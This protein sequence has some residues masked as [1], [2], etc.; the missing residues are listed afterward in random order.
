MKTKNFTFVSCSDSLPI[1]VLASMPD[2]GRPAALLQLAH[3]M[4]GCKERF[5]PFMEYMADNGIGCVANDH[6]GHGE[7]IRSSGDL[8]YMYGNGGESLVEDMAQLTF[9]IYDAFPG[10]PVFLLGHSMGSMAARVYT[11]RHDDLIE[12]L[13]LCGSPSWT[14]F[15]H[16]GYIFTGAIDI[17]GGGRLRPAFLSDFVSRQYNRHF[18]KEGPRAWTCSDPEI[19]KEFENNP[20]CNYTFTVNGMLNLMELMLMTYRSNDWQMYHP[21]M[22]VL[23][24]SGEDDPCCRSEKM[25]HESAKDMC[26]HGYGNV[27]SALYRGMR[28][29]ILNEKEKENV[30][31]D[32]LLF[33]KSNIIC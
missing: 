9:L 19:R 27:S 30:W 23:F 3:G 5:L 33:I 31:N 13:I 22:P 1:S 28:H 25:F 16:L 18:S 20:K 29:E 14:P 8:G 2:D 15:A 6:R 7:S 32:I 21:D 4:C 10:T 17:F 26:R 11:Q 24:L 12:G